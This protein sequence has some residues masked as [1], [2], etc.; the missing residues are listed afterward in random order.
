MPAT[1]PQSRS[2]CWTLNNPTAQEVQ[3]LQALA[4]QVSYI[5][6]QKEI[7][8][9]GTVH[10]QGFT[11]F[12]RKVRLRTA[13]NLISPRAH[14]ETLRASPQEASN[15]CKKEQGR[16]EAPFESGTLVSQGKRTD[17]YDFN[18]A[19]KNGSND[20]QLLDEHLQSFY[21]YHKAIDRVRLAYTKQRDWEMENVC[22][23]GPSGVGK[24][25][26]ATLEAGI[27][28]YFLSKGDNNQSCWWDGYNGETSVIID[29]FYGWLPWTFILRLLDR[30]PFNVQFK[31]G[32][33]PFTS[34]KIFLTSNQHPEEWYKNIPNNDHTP[35]LRRIQNIT[36]ME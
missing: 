25:R 15:Y 31:G 28:V 11:Q 21:K 27:S 24:T 32:S 23:W 5:V 20:Q 30:Y 8:E 18:V 6:F 35:L 3:S 17:L 34:R 7:G 12:T 16:L 14:C 19:I 1:S 4:A 29:D 9:Q 22:Y 36:R 2:W 26:R 10:L 13:K 33:R